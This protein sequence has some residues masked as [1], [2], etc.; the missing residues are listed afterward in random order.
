MQGTGNYEIDEKK[1]GSPFF[2]EHCS[3]YPASS[4][5]IATGLSISACFVYF[6]DYFKNLFENFNDGT[7]SFWQ[8]YITSFQTSEFFKW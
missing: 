5:I 6:P 7:F 1:K 3:M 4:S 2:A 8:L